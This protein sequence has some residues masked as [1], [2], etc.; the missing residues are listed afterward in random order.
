[1]QKVVAEGVWRDSGRWIRVGRAGLNPGNTWTGMPYWPLDPE[2]MVENVPRRQLTR[3][4]RSNPRVQFS[5]TERYD[6]FF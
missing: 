1:M 4:I 2:S 3:A 5:S 6:L